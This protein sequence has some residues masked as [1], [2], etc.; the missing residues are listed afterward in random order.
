MRYWQQIVV[1]IITP[2]ALAGMSFW[3]GSAMVP[4]SGAWRCTQRAAEP[5]GETVCVQWTRAER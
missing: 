1:A 3:L 4:D 2:F 5:T